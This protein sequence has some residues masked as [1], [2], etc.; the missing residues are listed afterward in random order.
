[1]PEMLRAFAPMSAPV[2]CAEML[3]AE[4]TVRLVA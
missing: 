1:M 4:T 2:W 3:R